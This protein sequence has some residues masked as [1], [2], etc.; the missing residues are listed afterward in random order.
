MKKIMIT[1]ALVASLVTVGFSQDKKERSKAGKPA[2]E[3]TREESPVKSPQERAQRSTD[4]LEKKLNLSAD[5]KSQVYA[6]NLER[7][8]R[9]DKMKSDP[10]FKKD[11]MPK[12]KSYMEESD[13]KLNKILSAEQQKSYAEMKKQSQEKMK[14]RQPAGK[15]KE[16]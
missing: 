13:K 6:L 7:A 2:S 4:A 12:Q 3:Q 11:E 15:Q 5:Q 9:M 10:Q 14:A 1:A 16:G 8:E